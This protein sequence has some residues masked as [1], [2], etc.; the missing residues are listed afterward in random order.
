MKLITESAAFGLTS[1]IA[2]LFG[3]HIWM[4]YALLA[5]TAHLASRGSSVLKS[6]YYRL[7]LLGLAVALGYYGI[8]YI[9]HALT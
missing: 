4:D 7:L 3:F 9:L 5:A 2:F 6:R 1:G 8:T